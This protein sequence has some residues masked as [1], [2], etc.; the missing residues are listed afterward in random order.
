MVKAVTL[1]QVG[2]SVGATIPKDM[3][4]RLHRVVLTRHGRPA[5]LMIGI[6]AEVLEE[7]LLRSD[8]TFWRDL[9]ERRKANRTLSSEEMR[10]RLGMPAK[11]TRRRRGG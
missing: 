5:A 8:E 7:V 4:E 1:R 6:E 11:K 3:A 10:A 2:G 9:A